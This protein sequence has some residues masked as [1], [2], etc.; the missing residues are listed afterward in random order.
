MIERVAIQGSSGC[1]PLP[2]S[3][4]HWRGRTA[5]RRHRGGWATQL[6]REVDT[7][8]ACPPG[9]SRSRMLGRSGGP[10]LGSQ[11]SLRNCRRCGVQCR[12][13]DSGCRHL[14]R[15][16]TIRSSG[17]WSQTEAWQLEP[18]GA[19]DESRSTVAILRASAHSLEWLHL[20]RGACQ[21][22]RGTRTSRWRSPMPAGR[23]SHC[24]RP[25][26]A[27]VNDRR[28]HSV[29]CASVG[30]AATVQERVF[31]LYPT[32]PAAAISVGQ[33]DSTAVVA[34]ATPGRPR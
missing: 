23:T 33:R 2:R 17:S 13:Q 32:Q 10:C 28:R 24:G 26:P 22:S 5:R 4:T 27:S 8:W 12:G 25:V 15:T 7:C 14:L 1:G 30:A 31:G 29:L 19:M 6:D 34:M 11:Q 16:S 18:Q 21:G 9:G 3:A 20:E